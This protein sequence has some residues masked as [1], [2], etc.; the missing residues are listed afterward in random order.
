MNTIFHTEISHR[1]T[2]GV[3]LDVHVITEHLIDSLDA[4]H[5]RLVLH[6]LFLALVAQTLEKH[7]RIVLYL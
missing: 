3:W 5:E 6:N 1:R 2:C 7:Y 4:L